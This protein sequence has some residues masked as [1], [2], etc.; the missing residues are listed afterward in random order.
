MST[1]ANIVLV[2]PYNLIHQ[3]YLQHDGY[4]SY[5]GEELRNCLRY[6]IDLYKSNI[7]VS[8]YNTIVNELAKVDEY[9][10]EH[11][12]N[13]DDFHVI[14]GDVEYVYVIKD[15]KL[16]YAYYC[17]ELREKAETYQ[18]LIDYVCVNDNE[19]NL[20]KQV[21][22]EDY[23]YKFIEVRNDK[24]I[25]DF[26]LPSEIDGI[27]FKSGYYYEVTNKEALKPYFEDSEDDFKNFKSIVMYLYCFRGCY[28]P[29][30]ITYYAK[31]F[32]NLKEIGISGEFATVKDKI[33]NN[34]KA[35]EIFISKVKEIIP[36]FGLKIDLDKL[37][38]HKE[39]L[40]NQIKDVN[41]ELTEID[42]IIKNESKSD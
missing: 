27:K 10:D 19:I 29:D 32:T 3:F 41:D 1:R 16:Y 36:E 13:F 25:N 22:D 40:L 9:E 26:S 28:C 7:T 11:N 30:D 24:E 21:K 4:L 31:F 15:S 12:A 5:L 33:R 17:R 37:K 14:H 8:I 18:D 35:K 2:S 6:S 39:S 20:D 42:E 23:E 34:K 38:E